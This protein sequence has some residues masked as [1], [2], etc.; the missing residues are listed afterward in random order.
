MDR[1]IRQSILIIDDEAINLRIQGKALEAEYRVLT[2]NSVE[3]GLE[4]AQAEEPDL[5]LLDIM[6]PGIDGYEVCARLKAAAKTKD[7]PVI[8]VT[9]RSEVLE[10]AKG[11]EL[12][13]ID[14]LTK[15]VRLPV[16]KLK[17]K[18]HLEIRRQRSLLENLM[19]ELAVKNRQ[20]EILS[21]RDDLTGVAN[22]RNFN[23][24]LDLELRR[25]ARSNAS[26]SLLLCD[27]D[28]FKAYNDH[29]GHLAG[30]DCL[31]RIGFLMQRLFR[32]AGDLA[33][34]Y[35]GDEFAVILADTAAEEAFELGED[36][37][38][39]MLAEKIEQVPNVGS[40]LVTLSIGIITVEDFND[41][42]AEWLTAQ[43][44]EALYLSKKKGRNC[45]SLVRWPLSPART[46]SN[47]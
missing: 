25:A 47:C 2:A 16:L 38:S 13:A 36:L 11:I 37:R 6:M 8:F 19:A 43:A 21:R 4:I 31:R 27:I 46:I 34:R 3:M 32:R 28:Y 18:N 26:L 39:A 20:L 23:D 24:T 1:E 9:S 35:G 30:D 45:V 42:T 33:A 22:R 12:G 17:V 29:F 5:I 41:Q 10:E 15:P 40:E 7:I 44:D 14:Y